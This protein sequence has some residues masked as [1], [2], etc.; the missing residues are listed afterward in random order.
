M[1]NSQ[2]SN[3]R[4]GLLVDVSNLY[5]S[6]KHLFHG[7]VNY[8][9]LLKNLVGDRELIRAIA[10]TVKT[11]NPTG[12][13]AFFDALSKS[14]FEIKMKDLQIFPDGSKKA[15]WDVGIAVDAIRLSSS[16]DVVILVTGDGDFIPLVE[17]VKFGTGKFVEVAAFKRSCSGKLI[18]AAEKFINLEEMPRVIM[19]SD[20]PQRS[21]RKGKVPNNIP[22][23]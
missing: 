19:K 3:Q 23:Q 2:Y 14:G 13:D 10:Y 22:L 6:A 8:S 17:Y 18:E 7:K 20:K 4:V 9:E 12:E 5:H 15:D 16:L 1:K 21:Y 11:E